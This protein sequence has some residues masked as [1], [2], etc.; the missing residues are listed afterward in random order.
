MTSHGA[1]FSRVRM[2][3]LNG[4]GRYFRQTIIL[5]SVESPHITSLYN[6]MCHNYG[7]KIRV[8]PSYKTGTVSQVVVQ[9]PQVSFEH[10]CL[11]AIGYLHR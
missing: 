9:I 4:W 1:D 2:W 10:A 11:V 5:S 6:K 3:T 8:L 7:G